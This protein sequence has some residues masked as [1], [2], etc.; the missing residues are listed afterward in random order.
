MKTNFMYELEKGESK[1][2]VELKGGFIR[3]FHH[4]TGEELHK[5]F[6]RKGDWAEL[7][8]E[9][10]RA[11]RDGINVLG[12]RELSRET[13]IEILKYLAYGVSLFLGFKF[14]MFLIYVFN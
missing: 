14:L 11:D 3:V 5:R 2:V 1:I 13:S 10:S 6:A 12:R 8:T 4:E 7:W 9:L